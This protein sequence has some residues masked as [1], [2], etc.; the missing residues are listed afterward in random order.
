M[1][2]KLI[3]VI[4]ISL[5]TIYSTNLNATCPEGYSSSSATYSLI[6]PKT[7]LPCLFV[8]YYC[9]QFIPPTPPPNSTPGHVNIYIDDRWAEYPCSKDIPMDNIFFSSESNAISLNLAQV[10]PQQDFPPCGTDYTYYFYI[11]QK[12]CQFYFTKD[13]DGKLY[14]GP[15]SNTQ[16]SCV[17]TYSYCWNYVCS[18]PTVAYLYKT[19]SGGPDCGT[20]IPSIPPY[21]YTMYDTWSTDCFLTNSDCY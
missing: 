13:H 19:S 15:C 8:V 20:S 5:F 3:F 17:Y 2:T 6:N 12:M 18:C 7:Q 1:K 14:S 9:Y 16:G 21:G 4:V 11:F 10:L